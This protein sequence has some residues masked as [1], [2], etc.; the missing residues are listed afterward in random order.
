MSRT[1]L[2]PL[3]HLLRGA[4]TVT[5]LP[6]GYLDTLFSSRV[7]LEDKAPVSDSRDIVFRRIT[8][9]VNGMEPVMDDG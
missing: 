1:E 9:I 4:G 8:S 6:K 7:L 3:A 2:T 5:G